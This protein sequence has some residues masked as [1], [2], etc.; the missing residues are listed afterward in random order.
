MFTGI[1]ETT[2]EVLANAHNG[3]SNRLELSAVFPNLRLGE[4]LAVNGVC[5]TLVPTKSDRICFDLSPETLNLSNLGALI[6]GDKVNLER[7]MQAT[8]RFGGHYVNG[9]VDCKAKVSAIQW[10]GDYMHVT[11]TGF[12][13]KNFLYL[14]PKGSLTVD[15]V[16]LTI[17]VVSPSGIELMLIPHTLACTTLNTLKPGQEVNIE[18]DYLAQ[19]VAHQL[20]LM[21]HAL[22]VSQ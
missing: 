15:G 21:G 16:S 8:T 3:L 4:S 20:A 9:H 5:L 6:P 1:I 10:M 11:I 7:A 19:V 22:E 12:E 17:N 13:R 2:A 18:F 14:I